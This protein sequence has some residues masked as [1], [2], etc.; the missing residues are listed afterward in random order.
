MAI[1]LAPA[2]NGLAPTAY[3]GSAFRHQA[4]EWRYSQPG[5]GARTAGGRWNPPQ[6]FA[7]LY[8]ALSVETAEAE[9]RRLASRAG[10]RLTDFMPRHLLEFD[11]RLEAL[12]DLTRPGAL[13]AVG[14][15]SE[16]YGTEDAARCQE[17]GEVAHHLGREGIKAPSATGTGTVLAIFVERLQ[18]PSSLELVSTTTWSLL[19]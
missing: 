4:V 14:L 5:A 13:E 15:S 7:T 9:L 11:A 12:L 16:E 19:D 17:V 2:I 3:S 1:Q 10:R 8:L 18:P 6:S